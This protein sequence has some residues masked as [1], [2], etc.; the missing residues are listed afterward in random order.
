MRPEQLRVHIHCAPLAK[1]AAGSCDRSHAGKPR[2]MLPLSLL[3][4][5]L[6][7]L[8]CTSESIAHLYVSPACISNACRKFYCFQCTRRRS[9]TRPRAVLTDRLPVRT[10]AFAA[11]FAD[12]V[13]PV[14]Q[15]A[16]TDPQHDGI[17]RSRLVHLAQGKYDECDL[18]RR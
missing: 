17:E 3:L 10:F 2:H 12:L 6:A 9:C 18:D 8:T 7:G 16:Q 15:R 14:V 5:L 11:A 1:V 13:D 4:K